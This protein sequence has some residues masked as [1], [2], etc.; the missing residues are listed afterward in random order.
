[1]HISV[2]VSN[3]NTGLVK[4]RVSYALHNVQEI[5][6]MQMRQ[7]RESVNEA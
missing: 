3:I 2:M 4:D 7:E 5:I 6:I 1:M